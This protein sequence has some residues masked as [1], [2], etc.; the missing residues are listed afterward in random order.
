MEP[1]NQTQ[2][3]AKKLKKKIVN[4]CGEP[5]YKDN[6]DCGELEIK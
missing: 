2:V 1:K 4:H 6:I 3:N 5:R